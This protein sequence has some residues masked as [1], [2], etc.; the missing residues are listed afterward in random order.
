[1]THRLNQIYLKRQARLSQ[2]AALAMLCNVFGADLC[3][4]ILTFADV[5]HFSYQEL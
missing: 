3:S 1:M 2:F 4:G 5:K